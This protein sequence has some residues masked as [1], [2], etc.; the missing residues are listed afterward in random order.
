LTANGFA[1]CLCYGLLLIEIAHIRLGFSLNIWLVPGAIGGG[2]FVSRAQSALF[3]RC[4][5]NAAG[6]ALAC[7]L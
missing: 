3:Q 6:A 2:E 1:S 7:L 4:L 5:I